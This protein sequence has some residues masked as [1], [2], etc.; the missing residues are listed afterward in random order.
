MTPTST[1]KPW[2]PYL[3][4]VAAAL[5]P[6][7]GHVMLGVPNRGLVF[8]FFIILLGWVSV[9]LMPAD[10]SF[11]GKYIG[12]VFVYGLSVIDSYKRARISWEQWKF[13]HVS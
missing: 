9:N 6:G 12:G 11:V 4:L 8:L 1:R 3:V 10:A 5:L 7:S 13:A 2:N